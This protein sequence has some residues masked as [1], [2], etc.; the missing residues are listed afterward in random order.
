L[1]DK[2][3]YLT[4]YYNLKWDGKNIEEYEKKEKAKDFGSFEKYYNFLS[5]S[6]EKIFSNANDPNRNIILKQLG[7]ISTGYDSPTVTAL[8][9]KSGLNDVVTF[10]TGRKGSDDCGD[11]IARAMDVNLIKVSREAWKLSKLSEIPFIAAESRGEDVIFSGIPDSLLRNRIFLT[12]YYGDKVWNKYSNEQQFSDE[13]IRGD[14]AGLSLTE[15]RLWKGFIHVPVPFIGARQIKDINKVSNLDEMKKWNVSKPYNRPICRRIVEDLGVPRN[16]FGQK[17]CRA[18]VQLSH[19]WTFITENSQKE[20]YSWLSCQKHIF[21]QKRKLFPDKNIRFVINTY[22]RILIKGI[23]LLARIS[24]GL[25]FDMR[26]FKSSEA[27]IN[28]MYDYWFDFLYPWAVEQAKGKYRIKD[29]SS[30]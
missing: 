3:I 15:Y 5:E 21:R 10:D 17:K 6:I 25:S 7:T 14:I 11:D 16:A 2:K 4:Y 22:K 28:L 30:L 8:S 23:N 18:T 24:N 26:K 12:G 13:L 20:F 9:K 29:I 19:I 27:Y 1:N